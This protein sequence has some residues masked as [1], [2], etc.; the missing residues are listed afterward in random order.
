MPMQG[1]LK[2]ER[3]CE[4]ARVSRAELLSGTAEASTGGREHGSAVGDPADRAGAP[5]AE[6]KRREVAVNRKRWRG[7]WPFL[8]LSQQ[9]GLE[10]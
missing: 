3:M 8:D 4:L 6:L 1:S 2:V 7:S 5:A 10:M 9:A